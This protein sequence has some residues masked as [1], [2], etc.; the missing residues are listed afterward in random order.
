MHKPSTANIHQYKEGKTV[1]NK[2]I[3]MPVGTKVINL[4]P[5]GTKV[6]N[7]E[8]SRYKN[9]LKWDHQGISLPFSLFPI[10][11]WTR[12]FCKVLLK[13]SQSIEHSSL[14]DNSLSKHTLTK[15]TQRKQ[16]IN[17]ITG[18][19]KT[20]SRKSTNVTKRNYISFVSLRVSFWLFCYT[21]K[22]IIS[23]F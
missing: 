15:K 21:K 4:I 3:S 17:N 1:A 23:E 10:N 6:I 9:Q 2:D 14:F 13:S 11:Q 7:L 19:I 22:N 20:W 8:P 18:S 5:V 16:S 12:E